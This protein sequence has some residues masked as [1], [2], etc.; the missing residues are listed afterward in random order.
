[1][2]AAG[3]APGLRVNV[4]ALDRDFRAHPLE[5][6]DVQVNRARADRAAAGQ[7]DTRFAVPRD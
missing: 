3:E 1:M 4:A 7:R 2:R 6:R 5:S